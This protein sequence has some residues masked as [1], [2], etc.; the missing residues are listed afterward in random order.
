MTAGRGIMH[1]EMPQPVDRIS[2]VSTRGEPA[3]RLKMT[4][5]RT[6]RSCPPPSPVRR[7][8]WGRIRVIVGTVTD[9]Q[10]PVTDISADPTYLDAAFLVPASSSSP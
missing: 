1:E 5:P 10:R 9:V 7:V 8:R 6:R 4:R 2:P 3:R